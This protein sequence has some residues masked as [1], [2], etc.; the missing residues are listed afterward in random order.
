MSLMQDYYN[1]RAKEYEE[2]YERDDPVRLRELAEIATDMRD[3][4]RGL[5]V[6]EIA[7][8][9]GYWT[10]KLADTAR[11]IVATDASQ[12]MLEIARGKRLPKCVSLVRA[13]AYDLGSLEGTFGGGLANFW[14]SHVPRARIPEFLDGLHRRLGKGGRTFMADNCYQTGVGGELVQI[15][16]SADSFKRRHLSDGTAHLILKNYYD[17]EQLSS[18]FGPA[19]RSLKVQIGQ[20]YWWLSY[21]IA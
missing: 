19:A 17:R 14:F 11:S 2:I 6:L 18:I 20:C 7:C 10:D 5:H 9:T 12:E 8:G 15:E 21:E 3:T 1:R 16:G 4:L 13:D